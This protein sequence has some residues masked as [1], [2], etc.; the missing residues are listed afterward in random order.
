LNTEYTWNLR[1]TIFD[2]YFL[3]Y[4]RNSFHLFLSSIAVATSTTGCK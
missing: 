3:N 4:Q 1:C 2:A